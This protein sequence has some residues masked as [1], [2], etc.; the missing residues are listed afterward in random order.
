MLHCYLTSKLRIKR[1]NETV[2]AGLDIFLNTTLN[3]TPNKYFLL[4]LPPS[5][6]HVSFK[7]FKVTLSST[8]LYRSLLVLSP[9]M[10]YR[11]LLVFIIP[12]VILPLFIISAEIS[13]LKLQL[14]H[15]VLQIIRNA[16][17]TRRQNSALY[18]LLDNKY[19]K[20][21]LL[22]EPCCE[23]EA[24]QQKTDSLSRWLLF[25]LYFLLHYIDSKIRRTCT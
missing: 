2:Q 11:S 21:M 12:T 24:L 1:T 4:I 5:L 7:A 23:L 3:L 22:R 15:A 13:V 25:L 9:T 19:H 17:I 16:H 18:Y 8:M 6:H 10:L 14:C 20:N